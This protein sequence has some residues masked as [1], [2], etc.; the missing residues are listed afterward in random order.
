M[1]INLKQTLYFP[2]SKNSILRSRKQKALISSYKHAVNNSLRIKSK[3]ER[4]NEIKNLMKLYGD[5]KLII[6][7][8]SDVERMGE[9]PCSDNKSM[10]V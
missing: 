7:N 8:M 9:M 10:I 6:E 3:N 1:L 2:N 4:N 5:H